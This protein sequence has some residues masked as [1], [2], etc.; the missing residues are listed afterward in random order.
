M[1]FCF[2]G[3]FSDFSLVTAITS[4]EGT[5]RSLFFGWRHLWLQQERQHLTACP[6]CQS[7]LQCFDA[8]TLEPASVCGLV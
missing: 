4:V 8:S 7:I 6:R 3:K 1:S 2:F 5:F